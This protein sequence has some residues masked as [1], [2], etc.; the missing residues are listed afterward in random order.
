ML[1]RRVLGFFIIRLLFQKDKIAFQTPSEGSALDSPEVHF[2]S[3]FVRSFK[4]FS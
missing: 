3:V 4:R 1:G 2:I